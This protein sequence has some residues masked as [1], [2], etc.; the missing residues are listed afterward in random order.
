MG[1]ESTTLP[2]TLLLQGE[3]PFEPELIGKIEQNFQRK[4]IVSTR[5]EN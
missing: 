1:F 3:L 2:S 5:K 4:S